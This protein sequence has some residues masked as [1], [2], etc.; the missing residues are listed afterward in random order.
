ML[1]LEPLEVL[2][3]LPVLG[4]EFD[5]TLHFLLAPLPR[6]SSVRV[7][8]PEIVQR[9]SRVSGFKRGFLASGPGDG[10]LSILENLVCVDV[11]KTWLLKCKMRGLRREGR[12]PAGW[13][14]L[15]TNMSLLIEDC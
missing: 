5:M 2:L 6:Q 8:I 10:D 3:L 7:T 9:T 11:G 13:W 12:G 15:S 1:L 4:G 14:A